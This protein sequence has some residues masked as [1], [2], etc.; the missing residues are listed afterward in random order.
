[1]IPSQE[2]SEAIAPAAPC[3][4]IRLRQAT[5]CIYAGEKTPGAVFYRLLPAVLILPYPLF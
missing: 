4:Y 5:A 3:L 1:M 2:R